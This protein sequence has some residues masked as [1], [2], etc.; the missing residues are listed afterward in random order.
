MSPRSQE[1]LVVAGEASGAV[2]VAWF[3]S[4]TA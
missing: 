1:L 4:C 2:Q 3:R